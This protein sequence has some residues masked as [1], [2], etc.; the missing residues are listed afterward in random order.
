MEAPDVI[1]KIHELSDLELATL[2]CLIAKEHCI[3]STDSDGLDDLEQ[4]L[5]LVSDMF[6]QRFIHGA[7]SMTR[8]SLV[9]LAFRQL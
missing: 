7:D 8:L 3:I 4:E 9:F 5:Q 6:L 1:D 2:L